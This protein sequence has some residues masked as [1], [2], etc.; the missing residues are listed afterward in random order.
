MCAAEILGE[1]RNQM[2][3]GGKGLAGKVALVTGAGQGLG[4]AIA[5]RLAAD[6]ASVAVVDQDAD[7]AQSVAGEIA[8]AGLAAFPLSLDV[9]DRTAVEA[10]VVEVSRRAATPQILVNN[11]GGLTSQRSSWRSPRRS[12]IRLFD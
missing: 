9:T 10:M 8:R 5:R 6:G 11:V 4:E 12:G 3:G 1:A 2:R 7:L